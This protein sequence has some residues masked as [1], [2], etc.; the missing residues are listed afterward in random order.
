M[1]EL[2]NG[3]NRLDPDRRRR[4]MTEVSKPTEGGAR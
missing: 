3:R 4:A 1:M 2:M